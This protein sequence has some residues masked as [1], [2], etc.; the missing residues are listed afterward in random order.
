MSY[1]NL[2]PDNDKYQTNGTQITTT[3]TV[4][5]G[6]TGFFPGSLADSVLTASVDLGRKVDL[7]GSQVLQGEAIWGVYEAAA[8]TADSVADNGSGF[9][10]FTDVSHGLS[11][12]QVVAIRGATASSLNTLHVITA[13]PTADTFDTR[14]AYTASATA[15]DYSLVTGRFASMTAGAWIM[16]GG[17]STDVAEAGVH[18]SNQFG[19]LGTRRSIHFIEAIRTVRVATAIRAGYWHIYEGRWTTAPTEAQ[20]SFGQDDAARPSYAVPGELTYRT[21]GQPDGQG[22]GITSDEYKPKTG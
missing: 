13:V 18:T 14:V 15:G 1:Y 22:G 20:D 10:R 5:N 3:S 11:V 12:G 7:Y 6:G 2:F 17:V 4:I 9:C 19:T 8:V 21:S 16:R